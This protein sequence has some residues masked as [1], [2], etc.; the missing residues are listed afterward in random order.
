MMSHFNFEAFGH[1]WERPEHRETCHNASLGIGLP[2][3]G[4]IV[5]SELVHDV[6]VVVFKGLVVLIFTFFE[7]LWVVGFLI[8]FDKIK[9]F[10]IVSCLRRNH[11]DLLIGILARLS[12]QL[13]SASFKSV[14]LIDFVTLTNNFKN[15]LLQESAFD[16]VDTEHELE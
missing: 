13:S 14:H 5:S 6:F 15:S 12:V 10:Q 11:F 9:E 1:A 8:V 2:H 16:I 4:F 7:I 3:L